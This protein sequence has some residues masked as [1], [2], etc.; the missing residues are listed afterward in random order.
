MKLELERNVMQVETATRARQQGRQQK[1][2]I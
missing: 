1:T 2:L